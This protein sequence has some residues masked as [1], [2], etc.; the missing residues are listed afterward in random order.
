MEF[1]YING[2][3]TPSRPPPNTT[4]YALYKH[5]DF[6]L[7][8][9]GEVPAG[10]RGLNAQSGL[11]R[12]AQARQNRPGKGELDLTGISNVVHSVG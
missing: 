12:L 6:L 3:R 11:A 2:Y 4:I 7:S 1:G 8:Y 5:K 9:L 10:R